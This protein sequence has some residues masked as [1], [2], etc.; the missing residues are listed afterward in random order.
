ML[1]VLHGDL[2][3]V[4]EEA[5]TLVEPGSASSLRQLQVDM[6][7]MLVYAWYVNMCVYE[8]YMCVCRCK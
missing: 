4:A 6:R 5:V 8:L 7:G 1:Q 2:A 3:A